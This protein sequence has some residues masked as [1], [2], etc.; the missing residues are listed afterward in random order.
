VQWLGRTVLD[1]RL[2]RIGRALISYV[3]APIPDRE[4]LKSDIVMQPNSLLADLRP[5]DG[6]TVKPAP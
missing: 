2:C 6:G 1:S 4:R 3:K 5:V